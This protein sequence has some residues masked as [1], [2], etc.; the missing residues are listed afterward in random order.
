MVFMIFRIRC[1]GIDGVNKLLTAL[2]A[3]RCLWVFF[4]IAGAASAAAQLGGGTGWKAC[5][6]IFKVQWPTNAAEGERYWLTND[7]YH[8]EAFSNDGAFEPGNR[9]EPRTEQRFEPNYNRGEIQYQSMEMV[10]S[11]E[12][13]YC[14]FQIHTGQAESRPHGATTFMLFWF[15]GDGGSLHVY[16]RREIAKNLGNKWFQLNVDHN[17]ADRIIKV[18]INKTLV[19]TQ[20]D[21]G[22]GDFYFKDGVY[23]QRHRPTHRMDTYISDIQM[24]TN[25]LNE[26]SQTSRVN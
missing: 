18:W 14:I 16:D 4:L 20:E 22:A 8:C 15:A 26:A 1:P 23:A 21:N 12:N 10:P 19:W 13:S 3:R 5:P 25:S 24:W 6:V 17:L 9:T 7:I 11:N 2:S